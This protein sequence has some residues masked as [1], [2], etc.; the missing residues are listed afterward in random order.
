[1]PLEQDD[2]YPDEEG[3]LRNGKDGSMRLLSIM[4]C[5]TELDA[6]LQYPLGSWGVWHALSSLF[7]Y[8]LARYP[9]FFFFSCISSH[10]LSNGFPVFLNC[11]FI[12]SSYCSGLLM[13]ISNT[14]TTFFTIK[15]I[16]TRHFGQQGQF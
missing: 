7:L 2:L 3:S 15:K 13:Q 1:M 12:F 8:T 4:I 11:P 6:L 10:M 16:Y 14:F 5:E 9:V